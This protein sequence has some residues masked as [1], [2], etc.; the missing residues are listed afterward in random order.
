[1]NMN[2]VDAAERAPQLPLVILLMVTACAMVTLLLSIRRLNSVVGAFMLVAIWSRIISG[3]FYTITFAPLAGGLS[4]NAMMSVS[5]VC[6]GLLIVPTRTFT[7]RWVVPIYALII[8]IVI[9]AIINK[10]TS[11]AVDMLLKW[12]YVI[13]LTAAV[14][15]AMAKHGRDL[16]LTMILW[17]YAPIY[18]FQLLSVAL[19]VGKDTEGENALS[20]IGG[21]NHE[22]AFSIMLATFAAA[23]FLISHIRFP[24]KIFFVLLAVV[25]VLLAN[26]R[27]AILSMLPLVAGAVFVDGLSRFDR[28]SRIFVGFMLV[29]VVLIVAVFGVEAMS[30]RFADL[31]VVFNEYERFLIPPDQFSLAD[32]RVLSGRLHIWANYIFGYLN[33]SDMQ[34]LFGWGPNSWVGVFVK[35]A[36]NTLVSYLYELGPMGVL[37]LLTVWGTFIAGTLSVSDAAMRMRLLMAQTCF[38]LFNLATMPHWLIEGVILFSTIQGTMLYQLR[39]QTRV[40]FEPSLWQGEGPPLVRRQ[41]I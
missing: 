4:I 1:M 12:G 7:Q 13:V 22:A 23:S 25:G 29:P 31:A 5:I 37:A 28:K 36:H 17:C 16:V 3:A 11:G 21:Y 26:Y 35:Y 33:G 20:Y 38:L 24:Y 15:N 34:M 32:R 30:E 14:Y 40:A 19:G 8:V 2:A 18:I 41:M 27:T 9:S 10:S 6:V 39:A